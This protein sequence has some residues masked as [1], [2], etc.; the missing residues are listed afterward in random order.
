MHADS[1]PHQDE[2]P[3]G[4]WVEDETESEKILAA[5]KK[6]G[7]RGTLSDIVDACINDDVW[8]STH[9]ES[10]IRKEM[11]RRVSSVLRDKRAR[12]G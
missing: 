7:S 2:T 4:R 11:L 5:F 8:D 6:I 3:S 12:K 9:T 1:S 10:F